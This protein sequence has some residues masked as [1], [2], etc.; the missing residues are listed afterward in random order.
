MDFQT[1]PPIISNALLMY[2]YSTLYFQQCPP[3]RAWTISKLKMVSDSVKQPFI[4]VTAFVV[5]IALRV[6]VWTHSYTN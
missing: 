5:Y 2:T 4:L 3:L 1:F 6:P